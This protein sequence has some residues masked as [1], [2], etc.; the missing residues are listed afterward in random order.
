MEILIF[1]FVSGSTFS[2]FIVIGWSL[3][4]NDAIL[5]ETTATQLLLGIWELVFDFFAKF[6]Y[7]DIWIVDKVAW[8]SSLI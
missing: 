6:L 4:F 3:V 5:S 8:D 7:I 2:G 1:C